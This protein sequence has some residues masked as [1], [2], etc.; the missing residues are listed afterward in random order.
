M[1]GPF[2]KAGLPTTALA[3]PDEARHV[4][5]TGKVWLIGAGPGDPGLIT[6][7]GLEAL[8]SADAVVYDRLA[9]QALLD[10]CHHRTER[11]DVGKIP[12]RSSVGQDEINALLIR[13]ARDGKRVARL[14]GG[15]PYVFGRGGEEALALTEA[16]V[17]WEEVPGVSA[18]VAAAAYAGIPVTHRGVA[19]SFAVLTGHDGLA[20]PRVA[21]ADTLVILMGVAH[22][23]EIVERLRDLGRDPD[24][25][26]ALV[27]RASTPRQRT[28]RA[29]LRNIVEE[30][31]R[32]DVAAPAT[33][34]VGP[35]VRL[36]ER[37]DW[38]ERRPLF[39]R[40][41]VVARTRSQES[42][43]AADL[44]SRGAEVI[45]LPTPR[46]Q[47]ADP[48]PLD[49]ALGDLSAGRFGWI[50]FGSPWIV[51]TVWDRLDA[52]GMDS[53]DVRARV[54]GYGPQ[55]VE[56]LSQ[57]GIR[58]DWAAPD[59]YAAA[60]ARGLRDR[61]ALDHA[62]F[63][64]GIKAGEAMYRELRAAGARVLELPLAGT[65]SAAAHQTDAAHLRAL[66]AGGV[67][68]FVF[69]ASRGV[70]RIADLLDQDVSAMNVATVVCMG[71]STASTARRLGLRVD[72]IADGRSRAAL[73][74]TVV[75]LL[76]PESVRQTP[77]FGVGTERP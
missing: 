16:G 42:R 29:R 32:Q 1:R 66:L 27:Q 2:D 56:A 67:D 59:Y 49:R 31:D 9:P 21:D 40:R 24:D 71:P 13:L 43:L 72:G 17:D 33:L 36:A 11:H 28:I 18:A 62:V 35:A 68:A 15:D 38:F 64:P 48:G 8:R 46:V 74:D 14:K 44:R 58:A 47:A 57:R 34:V 20:R 6:V 51:A 73:V 45:E 10:A 26:V 65:D 23:R 70:E 52:L 5:S 55:T 39:G 7:R 69:A 4:E 22:L 19:E 76:D 75:R 61:G 30:V 54:C 77:A 12:G 53:R 3:R 60:V 41:V 50:V 25:P 63:V 37:L